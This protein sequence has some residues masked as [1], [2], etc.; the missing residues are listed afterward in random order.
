MKKAIKYIG[1]AI[2]SLFALFTACDRENDF[3][4]V[5]R[6]QVFLSSPIN[7][8]AWVLN[9][10][11]PDSLYTFGWNSKRNF[12]NYRLVFSLNKDMSEPKKA[13]DVGV[14]QNFL[15]TT[16]QLDS[17][18][19]SMNIGIAE[20]ADVYWTVELL[21]P[22]DG[23][24]EDVWKLNITR[25]DLPNNVILLEAPAS[26]AN[27]TLDKS[28]PEGLI[29]FT[30]DC[31]TDVDNYVLE[32]SF[33]ED[34]TNAFS[35]EKGVSKTH[36]FT[37]EYLD[38]LLKDNR[39]ELGET[40]AVF[41][42]VKGEGNS[43]NPI[44]NSAEREL[45]IT[46][47]ARDPVQVMLLSPAKN[48]DIAL[49]IENADDLFK[50]EWE[51]DTTGVS[52]SVRLWDKE[53]EHTVVFNAGTNNYFALKQVDLDL[54]LEQEFDMV[55]SQKKIMYWEV[56][57]DDELKAI[58][59]SKNNFTLQR[60][61]AVTSAHPIILTTA[62]VNG[63]S[64]VLN[65]ASAGTVL[66][67]IAWDCAS[68][69]ATYAVE[70][71][72]KSD[73]SESKTLELSRDKSFTFT[74]NTFD[75]MLSDLGGA[76]LTKTVYWRITS[77]VNVLTEPSETRSLSL[78]GMLRPFLDKR[79]P[80]NPETYNVVKIGENFWFAE[81]LRATRYSDGTPFT[82]V[83]LPSKTYTGGAISDKNVIGQFYTW[84]TALRT[85][86]NA[87]TGDN[88]VM[89]GV[90]PCGWHVS[91]KKEWEDMITALGDSPAMKAKSTQ[92]WA[93]K[94]G[95]TNSSGLGLTPGGI[96]WHGN[97]AAP[98]NAGADGKSGYWTTTVGSAS[99]AYM[100]EVFDWDAA[101]LVPWHYSSRPWS[102]G[103]GTASRMVFVRCV[104]TQN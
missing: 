89:Q 12:V 83:D 33:D 32:L 23:W 94:A 74:H 10:Q 60:F 20:S 101:N 58:S 40:V 55:P 18:M 48:S 90:C 49:L 26:L 54:L 104:R 86:Q 57:P 21:D 80:S 73:M 96:F 69:T 56:I 68:T 63:T 11:K 79:D 15:L 17:M 30:W 81:N 39:I 59:P 100:F 44:E 70:Y 53:L 51:C 14:R 87:T 38:N 22:K 98:D 4:E 91:T 2:V 41:W 97:V 50:F 37:H 102:E 1:L 46:R 103:D 5:G 28:N 93:N 45:S 9:Y 72:L 65:Y 99:S 7:D 77:T 95:I 24:C 47:F 42:R 8:T 66:T 84:P 27:L 85:W 3:Y 31:L 52:F 62:P 34:F 19:S 16:M 76:Y 71:S 35:F 92:H 88:T 64:Y 25:C 6:Q 61:Q 75:G 13:I 67:N 82:A 78:R 36:E 29:T 43:N